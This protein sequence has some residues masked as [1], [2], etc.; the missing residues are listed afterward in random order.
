MTT[1]TTD[2]S[3]H[4]VEAVDRAKAYMQK[5]IGERISADDLARSALFSKFHFSRVFRRITGVS[6]GQYL[7][8]L[9]LQEAKR[10]LRTSDMKIIDITY[11][12]GYASVG[13]FSA[14]FRAQ[15]GLSPSGYRQQYGA[16]PWT[17]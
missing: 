8:E 4:S 14:R 13:T 6:P 2:F 3:S 1:S 12:V 16:R 5:R 7:A 9:R 17:A 15:V 10:L 11:A